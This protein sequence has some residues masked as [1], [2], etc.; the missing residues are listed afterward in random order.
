M[1][2]FHFDSWLMFVLFS[3]TYSW[4][5]LPFRCHHAYGNS[6]RDADYWSGPLSKA[7]C[8]V[9]QVL[10]VCI[11]QWERVRGCRSSV[12]LFLYWLLSVVC[13]LVPL[14]AKIQLAI[15]QVREMTHTSNLGHPFHSPVLK[16]KKTTH[17]HT[18]VY[19]PSHTNEHTQ[20]KHWE[21]HACRH[22]HRTWHTIETCPGQLFLLRV[23]LFVCYGLSHDV[24]EHI[25]C[26]SV[27][28]GTIPQNVSTYIWWNARSPFIDR[29][30]ALCV[31][32]CG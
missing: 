1:L 11:I 16:A 30:S 17:S 6:T 19:N 27:K 2:I 8:C 9:C 28:S 29:M 3:P 22:V 4:S 12:V 23:C 10:A 26:S 31:G 7:G 24:Y 5:A 15:E 25:Q 21:K 20:C 32:M 14:R 13:S 18:P